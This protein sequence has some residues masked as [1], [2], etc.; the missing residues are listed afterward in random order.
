MPDSKAAIPD[1]RWP[2]SPK[3]ASLLGIDPAKVLGWIRAGQLRAVNVG[4]GNRP[5]YRINPSELERF[6]ASRSTTA[7]PPKPAR[8]KKSSVVRKFY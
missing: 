1:G 6:I 4:N 3:V 2:S 7:P 8:R 5:L